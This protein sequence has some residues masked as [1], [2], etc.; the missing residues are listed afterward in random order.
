MAADPS[1]G[2][3]PRESGLYGG[4]VEDVLAELL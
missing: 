2:H 1:T 3:E 4:G